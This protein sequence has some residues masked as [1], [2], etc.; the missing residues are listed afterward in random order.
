MQFCGIDKTNVGFV[1]TSSFVKDANLKPDDIPN[2]LSLV[3]HP[4]TDQHTFSITNNHSS[5][6][7]MCL[8]RSVQ[9]QP[10]VRPSATNNF[11]PIMVILGRRVGVKYFIAFQ[12]FGWGSIC[13]AH[14][15][16]KNS[17]HLIALRL[18][19]GGMAQTPMGQLFSRL[20]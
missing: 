16:I 12:L 9:D 6:R 4:D 14:A 10:D 13:M 18:L 19:L 5:L 2:S 8:S 11:Q 7:P 3:S 17:G 20:S 15:G 1:A